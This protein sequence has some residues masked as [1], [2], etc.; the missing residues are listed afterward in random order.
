MPWEPAIMF[1]RE[2]IGADRVMY[3]MDYPYQF[4]VAEVDAQDALPI[5]DVE[6]RDFF[7]VTARKVFGLE[8]RATGEDLDSSLIS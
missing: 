7:E 6:K 1:T 3:A 4:D 2:V 8:F 5:S